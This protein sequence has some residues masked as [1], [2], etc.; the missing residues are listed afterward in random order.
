MELLSL[1]FFL[2]LSLSLYIITIEITIEQAVIA[3]LIAY[4]RGTTLV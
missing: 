1:S 2:F 3:S 4:R